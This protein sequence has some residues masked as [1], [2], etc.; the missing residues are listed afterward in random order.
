MR[1]LNIALVASLL[2]NA[3]TVTGDIS[4]IDAHV[5]RSREETTDLSPAAITITRIQ[6]GAIALVID[7]TVQPMKQLLDNRRYY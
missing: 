5:S 1:G 4:L 6:A 7:T 2:G 3:C